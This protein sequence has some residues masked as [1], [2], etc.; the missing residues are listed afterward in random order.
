MIINNHNT[1]YCKECLSFGKSCFKILNTSDLKKLE[2]YKVVDYYKKN[3]IVFRSGHTPTGLFCLSSGKVKISKNG[4]DGKEQII[5]IATPGS[6]IGLRALFANSE[7]YCSAKTLEDSSICF[8]P[9]T[10]FSELQ[11]KYSELSCCMMTTLS[12]MLSEAEEKND[13][14]GSK[15][16]RE[17]VAETLVNL[18]NIYV[19]HPSL[20]SNENKCIC[21]KRDDLANIAGTATETVIRLLSSFK[22]DKVISIEGRSIYVKDLNKLKK[23]AA[24]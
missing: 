9:K 2:K 15:P 5:R 23:I 20:K 16:V 18:Y 4:L 7:Y 6:M 17:R 1:K 21:I 11:D 3:E 12:R 14:N 19:N 13:I 10:L 8:I 24:L 22:E